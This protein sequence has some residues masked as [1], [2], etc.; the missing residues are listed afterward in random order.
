MLQAPSTEA[1]IPTAAPPVPAQKAS[2]R[3]RSAVAASEVDA[4]AADPVSLADMQQE[5]VGALLKRYQGTL[6][7]HTDAARTKTVTW[8]CPSKE[9]HW[10]GLD[11]SDATCVRK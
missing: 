8:C 6:A 11:V 4:P 1:A 7:F 9:C 10:N 5:S 2:G 3:L